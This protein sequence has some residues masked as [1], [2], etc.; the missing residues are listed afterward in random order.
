MLNI[1]GFKNY[2][3]LL[4]QIKHTLSLIS[5]IVPSRPFPK[6]WRFLEVTENIY[7]KSFTSVALQLSVKNGNHER[8]RW[9]YIL[10]VV[11]K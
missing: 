5:I 10:G 11:K 1:L 6:Y 9:V 4:G 7:K 3:L 8:F 2:F